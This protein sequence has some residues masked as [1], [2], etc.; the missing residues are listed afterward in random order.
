V[1]SATYVVANDIIAALLYGQYDVVDQAISELSAEG[2]SARTFLTVMAILMTSLLV[3]FGV[4]VWRSAS[5][6]RLL[7]ITGALLV[8][9]GISNLAWLPFPMSARADIA[10]GTSS[11]NDVG[12]LVMTGLTV[13]LILAQMGFSA[14]ASAGA[15]RVFTVIGVCLVLAFGA[16]TSWQAASIAL[17]EPTPLMGLYERVC[18]G[19]WLLWMAV[20][21]VLL[22]RA[23]SARPSD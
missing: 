12:H 2:S 17:G 14:A 11:G 3:A 13:L 15:F 10:A 21:S 16:L 22:L 23:P 19:A 1:Y 20:L 8:I 7:R 18:V 5:D 6:N 9:S 4:G